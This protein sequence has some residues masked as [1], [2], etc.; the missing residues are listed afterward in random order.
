MA[1]VDYSVE[2]LLKYK[3]DVQEE[4]DFD[5]FWSETLEHTRSY[6]LS[7][8][9]KEVKGMFE[10][11]KVYDVTFSGYAGQRIKGWY[12]RPNTDKK[13]PAVLEFIGY[14]GGRGLPHDWLIFASAGYGHFIMDTRGQGSAWSPGDTPDIEDI[15][16]NPH[17]PGFMTKG[18]ESRESYYYR[19][20]FCDAVRAYETLNSRDDIITDKVA[21]LGSSQGGGITLAA[22]GLI[23]EV[24]YILPDVPFLTH[25][26]RAVRNFDSYPYKEIRDYLNVHRDSTDR[27][28]KTLSYFDGVNFCKRAKAKAF[29]STALM[30]DVCPPSTVY[31]AY[32]HYQEDKEIIYWEFN[33]HES[34]ATYQKKKWLGILKTIFK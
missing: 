7:P 29:F 8:E 15:T 12:I 26:S 14:G 33:G 3:P 25:Y 5:K 32:N 23:P 11:V 19:R 1:F 28:F 22:A 2:E 13:V 34:G 27:V 16:G 10:T 9:F 6:A 4:R 18:I 30:D 21:V 20:V 17:Y 24:K 31:A